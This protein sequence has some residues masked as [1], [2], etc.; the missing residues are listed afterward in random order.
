MLNLNQMTIKAEFAKR[1]AIAL[2]EKWPGER[3]QTHWAKQLDIPPPTLSEWLN[4][5]KM[6]GTERLIEICLKLGVSLE[7]MA[8]GRGL[9]HPQKSQKV[10]I[11][12][13]D[14]EKKLL[15][16]IMQLLSE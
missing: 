3:M 10:P 11:F 9:K 16:K 8:T 13:S 12:L 14:D 7:W 5:I 6:P 4:G 2:Q 1:L 15:I